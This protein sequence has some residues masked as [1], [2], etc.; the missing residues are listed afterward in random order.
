MCLCGKS[1]TGG[2]HFRAACTSPRLAHSWLSVYSGFR[3][4]CS[5]GR[6][7]RGGFCVVLL[8]ETL[9]T[10]RVERVSQYLVGKSARTWHLLAA[11]GS[12]IEASCPST[13]THCSPLSWS[14]TG[15]QGAITLSGSSLNH[16]TKRDTWASQEVES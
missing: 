14:K 3:R 13:A 1:A 16:C 11:D 4:I 10:H 15:L 8:V 12:H 7:F 5:N 6:D 9:E 2:A